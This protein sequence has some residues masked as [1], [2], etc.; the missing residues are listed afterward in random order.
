MVIFCFFRIR[1]KIRIQFWM[2]TNDYNK[3]L[4]AY[5]EYMQF[6]YYL[7]RIRSLILCPEFFRS[8]IR[9]EIF[10][11]RTPLISSQQ[12]IMTSL[13]GY[14]VYVETVLM[15]CLEVMKFERDAARLA[16]LAH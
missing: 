8:R 6:V 12:N 1:I 10:R 2:I 3:L 14:V 11:L 7:Y 4:V 15:R 9:I 5:W 16:V 13:F